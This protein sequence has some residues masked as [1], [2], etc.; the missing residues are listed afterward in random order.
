MSNYLVT[1][2]NAT[3]NIDVRPS[4]R[5][6]SAYGKTHL[7]ALTI[8]Q[9][10]SGRQQQVPAAALFVL[11]GAEPHTDWLKDTVQSDEHGFILTGNDIPGSAWNA[12]RMPCLSKQVGP[13]CSPPA[14]SAMGQSSVS[15]APLERARSP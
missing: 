8:E 7:E 9:L 15:P 11:I 14:T 4:T 12:P 2:L 13:G 10:R 6:V 3:A 1:H 5:V